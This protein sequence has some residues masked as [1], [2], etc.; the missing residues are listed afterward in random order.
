M[1]K[2]VKADYP[3]EAM[4]SGAQ[5][6]VWMK[7]VVGRDGRT[8]SIEVTKSVEPR[9]D[10]AAVAALRQWEFTPGAKDGEPVPVRITIE[11]RF[12]LKESSP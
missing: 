11:M 2:E 5:G 6:V 7:C 8:S 12:T 9:I 1:V 10:E 3:K 4:D